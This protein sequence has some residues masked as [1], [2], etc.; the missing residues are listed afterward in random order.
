MKI[1]DRVN[2]LST[3]SKALVVGAGRALSAVPA[4]ATSPLTDT[5][6]YDPTPIITELTTYVGLLIVAVIP[7]LIL[8][9]T[10]PMAI[11]WVVG[12]VKKIHL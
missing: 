5:A 2:A 8:R 12:T 1:L 4:F 11:R 10:L 9:V 6:T 7:L 3:R